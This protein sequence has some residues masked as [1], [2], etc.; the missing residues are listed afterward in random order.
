VNADAGI[1]LAVAAA[2]A[3]VEPARL[4]R[5]AG[6]C[7]TLLRASKTELRRLGAPEQF[8]TELV[9]AR[10]MDV[11]AY[12]QELA[13]RGIA[14]SGF[15]EAGYPAV[16]AQL[17]DPPVALYS[18]G[19]GPALDTAPVQISI[20]GSR[21]P[22]DYGLGLTRE[23]AEFSARN[24]VPVVSGI[25]LGI[26][27]AAHAGA[28]GGGGPTFAV[29][30]CGVD[31]VYPRTNA[32]LFERVLER[33]LVVSEYPPGVAP[34]PWRFPARNRI[35]AALSG[36]L[37]VVEAR[38]KSGALITAD[39]ALDLGRDVLA[40]PGSPASSGSAGTNGLIKMGAGLIENTADLAGWLGIEGGRDPDLAL[41]EHLAPLM[42]E[43]G[44]EPVYPDALCDRL[45]MSAADVAAAVTRLEIDGWVARDHAG[46]I[47]PVRRMSTIA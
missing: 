27:A 40:V 15:G 10:T 42:A 24:G 33:G 13:E 8:I 2:A 28:L 23:L 37:L 47:A 22:S 12:R 46:R 32:R 14:V 9:S 34:A 43:I 36:T 29:L 11:R 16:L 21:R 26:D 1:R 5:R 30:G 25:A 38:I 39:Q 44:R 19:S 45:Q 6:G 35:I 7:H 18:R 20:V 31:V 3:S 17:A 4:A 41:P